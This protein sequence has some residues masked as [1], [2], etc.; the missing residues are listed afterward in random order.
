MFWCLKNIELLLI[1]FFF[2]CYC[3]VCNSALPVQMC[4]LH[5]CDLSVCT[6][7]MGSGSGENHNVSWAGS[8]LLWYGVWGHRKGRG[9]R[10]TWDQSGHQD[11][12]WICQYAW[13]H[14]VLERSFSYEGVQLSPCG[15][16]EGKI[17]S[18]IQLV[19]SHSYRYLYKCIISMPLAASNKWQNDAFQIDCADR[20]LN[21]FIVSQCNFSSHSFLYPV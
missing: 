15:K 1:F 6:R 3:H 4:W 2:H 16:N 14:W 17:S 10:W 13:T 7:W 21:V 5:F 19:V 18:S 12:K 8:G 9:Q 20:F 11:C